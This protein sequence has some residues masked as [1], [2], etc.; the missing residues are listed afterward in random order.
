MTVTVTI[1]TTAIAVTMAPM[2][3]TE[4]VRQG[5]SSASLTLPNF[6][7]AIDSPERPAHDDL[8]IAE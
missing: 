6:R 4:R 5:H 8:D 1:E 2:V 7:T 3:M